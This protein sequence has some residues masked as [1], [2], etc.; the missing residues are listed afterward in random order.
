MKK[1]DLDIIDQY[2]DGTLSFEEKTAFELRLGNDGEF[3]REFEQ[4]KLIIKGI[5]SIALIEEL[6]RIRQTMRFLEQGGI[7]LREHKNE[8]GENVLEKLTIDENWNP[9]MVCENRQN[10]M[11]MIRKLVKDH[12]ERFRTL[13]T[14]TDITKSK[15]R[16]S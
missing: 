8:S 4:I 6:E 10:C 5:Q 16:V 3:F 7:L 1:R 2:L 12:P 13:Q 11:R 14:N 9:V 15:L